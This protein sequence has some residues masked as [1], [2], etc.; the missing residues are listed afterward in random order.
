MYI[1]SSLNK[2]YIYTYIIIRH[3]SS[4]LSLQSFCSGS[5]STRRPHTHF[6]LLLF[7]SITFRSFTSSFFSLV[8]LIHSL[9]RLLFTLLSLYISYITL[10]RMSLDNGI[11]HT[12][13]FPKNIHYI[14]H[15]KKKKKNIININIIFCI[16]KL[17]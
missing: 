6:S 17:Y 2:I 7:H 11:L 5:S 3:L 16:Y 4:L 14:I 1:S 8:C 12:Y 15:S 13:I 10:Y 9:T